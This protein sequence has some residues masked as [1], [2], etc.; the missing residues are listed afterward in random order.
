MYSTRKIT[1]FIL[2]S[3]IIVFTLVA[4]LGIWGVIDLE[5]I[6]TKVLSSLL[7]VFVASAVVLFITT[8]LIK[9]DQA[10]NQN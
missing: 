10:K 4:I 7:V 9:E 6:M 2:V 1:G 5:D 8:V 3:L